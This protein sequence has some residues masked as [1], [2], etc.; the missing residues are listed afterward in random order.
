MKGDHFEDY[1][2][3]AE[4]LKGIYEK[5]YDTPSPVQEEVIPVALERKNI[6]AR[7]KMVRGRLALLLFPYC[8]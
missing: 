3:S 5:G 4:L 7:A 6:I 1:K 2:L 8:N